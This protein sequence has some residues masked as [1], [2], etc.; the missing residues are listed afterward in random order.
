[1]AERDGTR[2]RWSTKKHVK[3]ER[4]LSK[5]R[6]GRWIITYACSLRHVHREG[7]DTVKGNA[8]A[9]L[10]ACRTAAQRDAA[11]CPRLERQ[12]ALAAQHAAAAHEATR[13]L[14]ADWC[15]EWLAWAKLHHKGLCHGSQPRHPVEPHLRLPQTRRDH[16]RWR[17]GLLV[18]AAGL[19][20][21]DDLQSL[22]HSPSSHALAGRASRAPGPQ[23][24][25]G[26]RAPP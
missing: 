5:R 19:L 18:E 8:R 12:R 21:P 24:R 15:I 22:S 11:W 2:E 16:P 3:A 20:P 1:M 26:H 9:L 23:S 13:I 7:V 14:F 17:G 6:D 10:A 4:G 25:V